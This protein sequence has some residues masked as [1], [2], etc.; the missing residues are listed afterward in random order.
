MS[1][2]ISLGSLTS[3]FLVSFTAATVFPLSSEA[4]FLVLLDR[5]ETASVL[6]IIATLGNTLGACVNWWLGTLLRREVALPSKLRWLTADAGKL[7][8]AESWFAR[9]G[10]WSL[11]LAW[12]PIIGDA[13][14]VFAGVARVPLW[15]LA[16]LAGTG[17]F[18]RY[19]VLAGLFG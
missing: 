16:L 13:L 6:L 4:F 8:R 10:K 15:Q 12:A 3:L 11:L 9:V 1:E 2:L 17:K 7:V 19:L 18:C 5:S 14:T